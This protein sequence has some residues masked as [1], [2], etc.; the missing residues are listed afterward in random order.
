[1]ISEEAKE[2]LEVLSSIYGDDYILSKQSSTGTVAWGLACFRLKLRATPFPDG[3]FYASLTLVITLP[4]SYPTTPV[5]I[6]V[7]DA[8][9]LSENSIDE[10]K[11]LLDIEKSKLS[12]QV[13]CYELATLAREYI[14]AFNK[15][16]QT[17]YQSMESRKQR[18]ASALNDLR[19]TKF[20]EVGSGSLNE[21]RESQNSKADQMNTDTTPLEIR[22]ASGGD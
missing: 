16:P 14:E 15:K 2:E 13:M 19:T 9:G 18:E 12:G 20:K 10:L 22:G 17:L 11:V 5:I 7:E 1:M 4:K 8:K 6:T 3:T 21:F